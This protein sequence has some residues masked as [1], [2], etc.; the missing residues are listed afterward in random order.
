MYTDQGNQYV[1]KKPLLRD[2]FPTH[3]YVKHSA[4]EYVRG[5]V[6]TNTVESFFSVFKRGVGGIYQHISHAHLNR[7]L[8]EFDF[9]HNHRGKLGFDDE[10]RTRAMLKGIEGKK[11]M[12]KWPSA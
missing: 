6:H 9:R 12:Y 4:G 3:E 2:E 11:L 7:Y 8:S 10:M 5:D 1:R